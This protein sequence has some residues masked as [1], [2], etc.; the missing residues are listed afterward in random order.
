MNDGKPSATALLIA[1]S[2]LL[3]AKSDQAGDLIGAERAAYYRAFVEAAIGPGWRLTP[4]RR[5]WLLAMERL[6]IPGL[7]LHFTLRKRCIENIVESFLSTA[8]IE[9]VVMI[10]GGFD[11]LLAILARQFGRAVFLELD[12]PATQQIKRVALNGMGSPSNLTL[13]PVDLTK[14]AIDPVLLG[15]QFSPDKPTLFIA[16]GITMYLD[17]KDL[18]DLFREVHAQARHADSHF[19]FTFM[20]RQPSG[21]IQFESATCLVNWWLRLKQEAFRWGTATGE[22]PEFL[23]KLG[24]E[25]V[26]I[27]KPDDLLTLR[28][29]ADTRRGVA[30]AG[31]EIVCLAKVI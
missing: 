9:Q 24:Y 6:S 7:Y 4:A 25:L 20:N 1:Q 18:T 22:M 26:S 3:L 15:T 2:Q 8:R 12:H 21:S 5:W 23:A 19:L 28:R 10:A 16:E 31:G 13:I 17:E 30:P 27:R 29:P 11:P 14:Q